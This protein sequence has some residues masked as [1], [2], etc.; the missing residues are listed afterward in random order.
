MAITWTCFLCKIMYM[1]IIFMPWMYQQNDNNRRFESFILH[2][3][4]FPTPD[5]VGFSLLISVFSSASSSDTWTLDSAGDVWCIDHFLWSGSLYIHLSKIPPLAFISGGTPFTSNVTI[6]NR[7]NRGSLHR[8]GSS[9]L[10]SFVGLVWSKFRCSM[11]IV[12]IFV[13]ETALGIIAFLLKFADN[14]SALGLS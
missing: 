9:H 1:E 8:L 13:F 11:K 12:T 3:I 7:W 5:S 14:L 6:D 4:F 10:T 2:I